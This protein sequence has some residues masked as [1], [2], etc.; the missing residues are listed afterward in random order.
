M[1]SFV[2]I[3][4]LKECESKLVRYMMDH[5]GVQFQTPSEI[6]ELR[7]SIYN[8]M[9]NIDNNN[10][11]KTLSV[12]SFN[13]HVINQALSITLKRTSDVNTVQKRD[14]ELYGTRLISQGVPAPL[15]T[16]DIRKIDTVMSSHQAE[17]D[18]RSPAPSP[19][20]LTPSAETVGPLELSEFETR[21]DELTVSRGSPKISSLDWPK[22]H[23]IASSSSEPDV[24]A[25]LI[26]PA[27]VY[28]STTIVIK[29]LAIHAADRDLRSNPYRFNFAARISGTQDVTTL[30]GNYKNVCW[31][32]ATR[33][34]LPMEIVPTSGSV[35]D[36]KSFY[37]SEFSM[38]YPYIMVSLRDFSASYDGTNEF[39]RRAFA[40]FVYKRHYKA[41]N[42]RGYLLLEPA[43]DERQS[44]H[45]PLSSLKDL[46]VSITKP[47]GTLFNNSQDRYKAIHFQ[48]ENGYPL[49]LKVLLDQYYDRNELFVG[50]SIMFR[51]CVIEPRVGEQDPP[52]TLSVFTTFINRP[53]GHEIVQLGSVN[54][55]GFV[56][57]IYILAPGMF[58]TRVGRVII[59]E[60][61]ISI[62]S[63]LGQG[64]D[65]PSAKIQVSSP[66]SILN[67]SLQP[68]LMMRVGCQTGLAM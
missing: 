26:V 49:Y 2:N 21:L 67:M 56:N 25:D 47:N 15:S 33:L 31:L 53:Q 29:Y 42:G 62:V 36:T 59:D 34:V 65:D 14:L 24:R 45:T 52:Q 35:L 10:R 9:V 63:S 20:Q 22:Q 5:H 48:Y 57:A 28:D 1:A 46:H 17:I 64:S 38:A 41:P 18:S 6:L 66:A 39:L 60:A 27:P 16:S 44:F 40:L 54:E 50:D 3:D 11:S 51:D 43:Q 12:R 23:T 55:Q 30:S 61:M 8:V 4:N 32:E 37:S 68:V 19:A 58:D 13:N 7:Q